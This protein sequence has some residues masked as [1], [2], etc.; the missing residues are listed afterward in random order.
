MS[1]RWIIGYKLQAGKE[2]AFER[3]IRSRARTR[4]IREYRVPFI[5]ANSKWITAVEA[6]YKD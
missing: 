1:L 4:F 3:Y 5:G 6:D 2:A